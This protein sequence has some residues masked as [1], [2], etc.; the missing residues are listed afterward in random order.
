[1]SGNNN[2]GKQNRAPLPSFRDQFSDAPPAPNPQQYSYQNPPAYPNSAGGQDSVPMGFGSYP[3]SGYQVPTNQPYHAPYNPY[4]AAQPYS[5]YAA[6]P[7]PPP[8]VENAQPRY[9]TIAPAP[10][11]PLPAVDNTQSRYRAIAPAPPP[12]PPAVEDAQPRYQAIAPAPPGG[13]PPAPPRPR[14][15]P[16]R[17]PAA[18]GPGPTSSGLLVALP[19]IEHHLPNVPPMSYLSTLDQEEA[20]DIFLQAM[21]LRYP[22]RDRRALRSNCRHLY[23][24]ALDRNEQMHRMAEMARAQ[25]NAR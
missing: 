5:A 14:R 4:Q 9:R 10:P 19:E 6:P 24:A 13:I 11:P 18:P 8:A 20:I 17:V 23:Q 25:R 1:M 12:P 7:P 21:T 22:N 3:P 15:A 2:S 16:P